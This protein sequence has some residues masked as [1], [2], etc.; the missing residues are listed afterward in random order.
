MARLKRVVVCAVLT[1]L[2]LGVSGCIKRS[3][4]DAKVADLKNQAEKSAKAE[5]KA[6]QLQKELA[7]AKSEVEKA[8][9]AKKDADAK[10]KTLEEEATGLKEKTSQLQKDLAAAKSEVEKAEQAAKKDAEAKIK[11]LEEEAT[12]LKE[13]A[14]QLQ[15]DLDAAKSAVK[16]AEQAKKDAETWE[17]TLPKIVHTVRLEVLGSNRVRLVGKPNLVFNG[18]YQFDGKTLSMAAENP[19][20]PNFVWSLKKPGLFEMT[21]GGYLGASMKR[22]VASGADAGPSKG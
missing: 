10:I 17:I 7:A 1:A 16:K 11:T 3:E 4:Y 20:F 2:A 9:Q 6:S 12:G 8:E 15:K 13:K 22:K 18:V 5:A 14:S 19:V 21:A